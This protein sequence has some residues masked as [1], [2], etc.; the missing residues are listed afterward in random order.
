MEIL[1]ADGEPLRD[2]ETAYSGNPKG[3]SLQIQIESRL[4]A[5]IFRKK[6]LW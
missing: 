2:D 3:S 4:D 6:Q 5:P 1:K